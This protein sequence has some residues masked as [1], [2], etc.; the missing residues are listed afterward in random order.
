MRT[1]IKDLAESLTG[2]QTYLENSREKQIEWQRLPRPVRQVSDAITVTYHSPGA[3]SDLSVVKRGCLQHVNP[4]R[5][6][7]ARQYSISAWI[8]YG[9][10][11]DTVTCTCL[12][13]HILM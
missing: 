11:V 13:V 8:F 2:Y 3:L 10:D 9:I 5:G 6:T 7:D 12:F 1:D 4:G